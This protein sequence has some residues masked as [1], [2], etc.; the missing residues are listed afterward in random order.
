MSNGYQPP[1]DLALTTRECQPWPDPRELCARY[2][3]AR[4]AQGFGLEMGAQAFD[5]L[6]EI[7]IQQ[8]R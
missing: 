6:G 1:Q 8:G 4:L 5:D 2:L 3:L 7:A